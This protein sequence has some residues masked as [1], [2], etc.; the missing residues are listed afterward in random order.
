MERAS[1]VLVGLFCFLPL[2][3]ADL[4]DDVDLFTP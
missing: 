4:V 2:I 3:Y 1:L